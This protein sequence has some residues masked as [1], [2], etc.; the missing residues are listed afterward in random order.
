MDQRMRPQMGPETASSSAPRHGP[1]LAVRRYISLHQ[2]LFH[3]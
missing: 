3:P 2:H 1:M